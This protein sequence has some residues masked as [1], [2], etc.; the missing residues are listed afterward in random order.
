[1]DLSEYFQFC[2][3][4]FAFHVLNNLKCGQEAQNI[5]AGWKN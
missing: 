2:T 4:N 5:K 3:F 1:M